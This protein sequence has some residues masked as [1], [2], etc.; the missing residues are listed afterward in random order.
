MFYF[1]I[2]FFRLTIFILVHNYVAAA[3]GLVVWGLGET[4]AEWLTW[5][6][7]ELKNL[8]LPPPPNPPQHT[9]T[10]TLFHLVSVIFVGSVVFH[11]GEPLHRHPVSRAHAAGTLV[12]DPMRLK[13]QVLR[14]SVG[15][16]RVAR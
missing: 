1:F 12:L 15:H 8:H 4:L 6:S 14:R 7:G 13:T 5:W 16:V 3:L 2:F 9:L 11:A 10:V